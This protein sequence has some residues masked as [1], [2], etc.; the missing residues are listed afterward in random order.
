VIQLGEEPTRVLNVGAPGLDYLK[1][2]LLLDRT[3]F[4]KKIGFKLHPLSFL[5]TYHPVTLSKDNPEIPFNELLKALDEFPD[6]KII[7]T[8]ANA[9]TYG[10]IINRRIDEYAERQ[11]HRVKVFVTMGQQL[12]LS[13]LKYA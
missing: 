2:T 9:D 11:H 10:R 8:K 3:T 12:Y 4:E 13:A 7:F 1:R 5:V 6:A